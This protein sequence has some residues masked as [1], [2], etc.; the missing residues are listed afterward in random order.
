MPAV[1]AISLKEIIKVSYVYLLRSV[2]T[3]SSL[4]IT[5]LPDCSTKLGTACYW[6]RCLTSSDSKYNGACRF[7]NY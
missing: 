4:T 2:R 1:F 5:S 6:N 7:F 3:L